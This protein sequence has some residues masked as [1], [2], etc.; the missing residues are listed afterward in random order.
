MITVDGIDGAG[1]STQL[2]AMQQ[3]LEAAELDVVRTREPGG[4]ELGEKL[5]EILLQRGDLDIHSDAELLMMFSARA[6]HLHSVILPAIQVGKWV[7]CDRFTDASF[8]YQGAKGV[9]SERIAVLEHWVQQGLQPDATFLFDVP[10]KVGLARLNQRG[11]QD[12]FDSQ[13]VAYKEK[14]RELYLQRAAQNPSRFTVVDATEPLAQ[15]SQVVQQQIA[16][17]L[18]GRHQPRSSV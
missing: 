8:A 17:L 18:Q 3:Q 2:D 5:R 14:V 1:K 11:D 6:Q 9:A 12:Y 10:I 15:V 16:W 13:S 7:L 4:T